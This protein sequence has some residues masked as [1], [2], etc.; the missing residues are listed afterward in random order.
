MLPSSRHPLF[1]VVKMDRI[2]PAR[3]KKASAAEYSSSDSEGDD[4]DEFAIPSRN[5]HDNEFAYNPRKRRR[6]GRDAK[7]SAALGIFGSDSEEDANARSLKRKP[8]RN[9]GVSFV[10]SGTRTFED[11]DDDDDDDEEDSEDEEPGRRVQKSSAG[12]E[13]EAEEDEE[14]EEE[15]TGVGLGFGLGFHGA[16]AASE[17]PPAQTGWQPSTKA[18]SS[19]SFRG[20]Q[21]AFT[22]S[23]PLGASFTPSSAAEPILRVKDQQTP[24]KRNAM[25]SAFGQA[26]GGKPKV[27]PMSFG[28]RMMAKMGYVDGEGLGADR[29]GRNVIIEANL[30]PQNIGLG[31]VKEKSLKEREEEKRQAKLRGEEVVDSEEEERKKKA[32][33]KKKTLASRSG[34]GSAASTPRRQK[35]KYLTLDQV[36]KA[37]PGLNIPEAFTPILDMTGRAHKLLTSSS[38]LMTPTSSSAPPETAEA[39]ESRKLARRA[40]SDFMAI[41]EEWQSL[42]ER[43]AYLALQLQQEQQELDELTSGLETNQAIAAACGSISDPNDTT[44]APGERL[45]SI[46]SRLKDASSSLSDT[47]LPQIRD[48]LASLAVAAIHPTFKQF[49]QTWEPL[50]TP[51]PGFV[52]S[53]ISISDLLLIKREKPRRR[54]TATPFEAMM[55]KLWLP[56]MA[57]AIREWNVKHSDQMVSLFEAWQP[58]MP[59]FIRKQVLEQDIVR[60]LDEAVAK[61][62]PRRKNHHN[63]PHVWIFPWLQFL[64]PRQL[65]PKSS[66]GLVADVRRKFRQLIEAWEYR[67]GVIPGLKQWKEVLR[68]GNSDQWEPLVMNHLLPSMARYL[69]TNFRVAPE[70]QEPYMEMLEGILQWVDVIPPTMVGEV[71][72]SGVFPQWHQSLYQWLILDDASYE[73]IGQWFE[74][75]HDTALADIKDLPSISAEFAKGTALIEQALDLGDR[76]KAELKAPDARPALEAKDTRPSGKHPHHHHHHRETR[77]LPAPEP[78]EKTFRSNTE[79]WCEE[80]ELQFIPERKKVHVE[81]PLYRITAR[82][83]GRGGVLVYFK[84]DTLVAEK[85]NDVSLVVHPGIEAEW[86]N[87][88]DLASR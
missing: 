39:A 67:R 68:S 34:T 84:G 37:A 9:K 5:P 14:E 40:Q 44:S 45:E 10:S 79:D 86:A 36:K 13:A 62:E 72:A 76:V 30:R 42:Q 15:G 47:M 11:E 17:Q 35:P 6:T 38:G 71:I 7:E 73:E 3:L 51:K 80:N 59:G 75:W 27:N 32:A 87:L 66:N 85:K 55:Y 4:D 21:K 78:E 54:G 70:D 65:D 61:W 20:K 19:T 88:Y 24:T 57:A 50:E 12:G 28:A 53:L 60:K 74:W 31:A 1:D 41:L 83:D 23:A 25:P 8:L 22:A 63:L 2:D 64:P 33:R 69:K 16:T 82:G 56:R 43:K 81:G 46:I 48:E 29:Q 18:P 77:P 52:D 58:L 49:L 26:R